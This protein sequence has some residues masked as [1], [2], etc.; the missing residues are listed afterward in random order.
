MLNMAGQR[1]CSKREDDAYPGSTLESPREART[2]PAAMFSILLEAW[3]GFGLR[4]DNQP[5]LATSHLKR[6]LLPGFHLTELLGFS[7]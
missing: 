1:G 3:A 4:G 6:Q 5:L 2:K 7:L